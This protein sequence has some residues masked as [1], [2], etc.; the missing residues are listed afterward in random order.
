MV[1]GIDNLKEE[2][3]KHSALKEQKKLANEPATPTD[4]I[5]TDRSYFIQSLPTAWKQL[6]QQ[7]VDSQAPPWL[8]WKLSL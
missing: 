7:V 4:V 5:S 2:M 1:P 3:Q 6:S 8:G